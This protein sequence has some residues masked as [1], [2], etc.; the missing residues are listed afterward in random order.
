MN[1]TTYKWDAP[2][3]DAETGFGCPESPTGKGNHSAAWFQ[4]KE[5]AYCGAQGQAA[6]AEE[7]AP[8]S[9]YAPKPRPLDFLSLAGQKAPPRAWRLRDWM[10]AR[11]PH[12]LAGP[13]GASKSMLELQLGIFGALGREFFTPAHEPFTSLIVNCEDDHDELWRRTEQ[14]CDRFEVEMAGL[15]GK[16]HVESWV[17]CDNVLMTRNRDGLLLPTRA[18]DQLCEQVNDLGVDCLMLDNVAHFLAADH[19]SRTDVTQ[20]VNAVAGLVTD[21]PFSPIFT[22]HTARSQGSEFSG[23][24]AWEN[25]ARMRWFLG[26]R[27]PD[28]PVDANEDPGADTVRYLA[29]RKANYAG[30]GYV[31]FNMEDGLL[32]P[33]RPEEGPSGLVAAIDERRAEEV[34]LAGFRSLLGMGLQPSDKPSA[35]DY[36]PRQIVAKGLAAGYTTDQLKRAMNRLMREG[37]LAR[38][39]VGKYAN[40]SPKMGLVA[41]TPK[42]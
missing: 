1:W 29:K 41:P 2:P 22:L 32:V 31:R 10:L 23:S 20:F 9:A 19:D 25:A 42:A 33:D 30:L 3:A 21:R 15:I 36:L 39:E 40:R 35:S 7:T 14:I 8:E 34:C 6:N 26:R 27:L 16:L 38:G 24:A 13:G 28:Q 12:V 4:G 17:G 5:C 18:F 11:G 37:Q